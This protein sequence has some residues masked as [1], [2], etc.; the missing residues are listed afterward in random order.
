RNERGAAE[1]PAIDV[2]HRI[3]EVQRIDGGEA[4]FL[5]GVEQRTA[6]SHKRKH[7]L[8]RD[9]G[10][11]G[12]TG[13]ARCEH[14]VGWIGAG[15][16]GRRWRAAPLETAKPARPVCGGRQANDLAVSIFQ[17]TGG[18]EDGGANLLDYALIAFGWAFWID[19]DI[20]GAKTQRRNEQ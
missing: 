6:P 16:R 8:M 4:L 17:F 2:E 10:A 19:E 3:V 15:H 1:Q 12:L 9:N 18:E 13:R 20:G 14:D 11:F 7:A 5:R